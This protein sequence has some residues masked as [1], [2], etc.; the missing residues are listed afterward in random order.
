MAGLG[1]GATGS[2][3]AIY[4]GKL[5]IGFSNFA[6]YHS[7]G[8][9]EFV[10]NRLHTMK[11]VITH[12][13]NAI[14][15]GEDLPD[16]VQSE[17]AQA[18]DKI[19]GVMDY[20]ISSKEQD[21]EKHTSNNALMKEGADL[22]NLTPDEIKGIGMM[23]KDGHDIPTIIR[24]FDNKP[25]AQQITAIATAN[26]Q[27]GVAEAE[28]DYTK[29]RD[30][31]RKVD[32]GQPVSRQPKN[33]QTDYARKRA[34]EKRDLERFGESTNYWTRLQNERNTKIASL[35]SELTESIEKK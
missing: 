23:I 32:A 21:I 26:M 6:S 34:K 12:L 17:I 35:V 27:Q 4:A 11:R 16:W 14:G 15:R 8:E 24:I 28:T 20:S 9:G 3:G 7:Q 33:P 2:T 5:G 13:D 22:T 10:K 1:V 31:E 29:R 18:V 19:V 30:R 25:T